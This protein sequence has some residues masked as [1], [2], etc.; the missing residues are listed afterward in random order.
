MKS[1]VRTYRLV[2]S[3]VLGA[4]VL[5]MYFIP[6]VG[7]IRFGPI[8]A[9][10]LHIPVILGAIYGGPYVGMAV[11]LFFGILSVTQAPADPTFSFAWATGEFRNYMLVAVNAIVPRILIGLTSAL[12]YKA[13]KKIP[14]KTAVIIL[15]AAGT[16]ALGYSV[17]KLIDLIMAGGGLGTYFMFI[18]LIAAV[19]G[20]GI[21]IGLT[22][23]DRSISVVM[24]A[25]IGS[26]TNTIL[27]LSLAYWFFKDVFAQALNVTRLEIANIL[28][29]VGAVNGTLELVVS[30]VLVSAIAAALKPRELA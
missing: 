15:A 21:W 6:Q 5:V 8:L 1:S 14:Q 7:F 4:I 22:L 3:A 18:I 23:G 28:G 10:T 24:A 20:V 17:F 2:L 25:G 30:I 16:G 26:L 9:T 29:S 27:F 13:A 19:L 12:F 11:G